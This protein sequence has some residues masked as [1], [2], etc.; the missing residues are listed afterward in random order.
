M[1]NIQNSDN[2]LIS[3]RQNSTDIIFLAYFLTI[4]ITVAFKARKSRHASVC[5]INENTMK[6]RCSLFKSIALTF[7][8]SG[9]SVRVKLFATSATGLKE[10]MLT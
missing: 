5:I 10:T 6:W 7:R 8:L 3:H 2:T 1:D 4:K 9:K